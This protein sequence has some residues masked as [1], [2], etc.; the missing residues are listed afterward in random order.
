VASSANRSA[1]GAGEC[2]EDG[3]QA[4]RHPQADGLGRLQERQGQQGAPGVDEESIEEFEADLRANLYKLWNRLSS[5]SYF[6]PAVRAVEIPKK[7]G[8]GTRTLGVPTVADRIAQ[9]VV[10]MALEPSVEPAFHSDSYGYRPGRSALDAVTACRERCWKVDWV[11]DLDIKAFFDT[12]DHD[13][14]LKAVSRHT[15][16][17]WILLYVERWLKAPLQRHDGTIVARDRGTPQGSAI[18][19]LLANL[20][21]HYAFDRWMERKFPKVWF[22]R[23]CDDGVTRMQRRDRCRRSNQPSNAARVMEAGPSAVAL[24]EEAANHRKVR[25]SRAGVLSVA[26][27]AH[28]QCVR[29]G[30]GRR[31]RANRPM[32]C[33]K[34]IDESETEVESLLRDKPGSHLPTDQALSGIEAAR[35][36]SRRSC[37]TCEPVAPTLPQLFLRREGGPQAAETARGRVPTRGT[38]TDRRVVATK[39]GNAGGAKAPGRP[40][41]LD[42]QLRCRRS[43]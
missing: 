37:G 9:T 20:F 30:P 21:L 19:P 7:D 26:E 8:K 40:G 16:Q 29:Y 39:P 6:P 2:T 14:V 25:R 43:R 27:T 35:A 36:G 3:G 5:G 18:S 17:R 4:V 23:Y 12:V 15:E 13:L 41:V 24:Q 42:G 31:A 22:E 11:I 10:K 34:R 32:T 33:R 1:G 28:G 38:G